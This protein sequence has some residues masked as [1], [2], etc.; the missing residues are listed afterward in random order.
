MRIFNF[1]AP[2]SLASEDANAYVYFSTGVRLVEGSYILNNNSWIR[3]DS[4]HNFIPWKKLH[5]ITEYRNFS[6]KLSGN[7]SCL[8]EVFGLNLEDGYV[9]QKLVSSINGEIDNLRIPLSSTIQADLLYCIVT[10]ESPE[11]CIFNISLEADC[12]N[13]N[14]VNIAY[15]ICSFNREPYV[16]QFIQFIGR[17]LENNEDI[18][19]ILVENG[20]HY[21]IDYPKNFSVI[22]NK[23][24]GG[25]GGFTRGIIEALSKNCFTHIILADDDISIDRESI[26]RTISLLK[27][28]KAEYSDC[29]ISGTM[30]SLDQKWLQY[31]RTSELGEYGFQPKGAYI[32]VRDNQRVI[33]DIINE[34]K[35][36]LAGW[37]YCCI[38]VRVFREF[39]LPL[40]IFV[41]G[42]DVEFSYRCNRRIITM[43]GVCVWHEPFSKKYNEIMED[44]YLVRNMLILSF[45]YCDKLS[46]LRQIFFLKKTIR[47][48]LLCDYIAAYFNL[49]AARALFNKEYRSRS[50]E[51]HCDLMKQLRD[52]LKTIQSWKGDRVIFEP[53]QTS[54]ILSLVKLFFQYGL[55]VRFGEGVS[56]GGFGRRVSSFLGRRQII[57]YQ[58]NCNY[59][60]Y[61]FNWRTAIKLFVNLAFLS[62][63][64]FCRHRNL[65]QELI[66]FRKES[67]TS[68]SW[69][70]IFNK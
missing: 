54:K 64:L 67:I 20:N 50:D 6:L 30:L 45:Q 7:G 17:D 65:E 10:S 56:N 44:Y 53:K 70:D 42:D 48:I 33:R 23:N 14:D 36:G 21:E 15:V 46:K 8:I 40:P 29:F 27:G 25:A 22:K 35:I 41:R 38:P 69:E 12:P 59:R 37:W 51:L 58:G 61:K 39:G 28:L 24:V 31:E 3:F 16:K 55:G 68:S 9:S 26:D 5:E 4:F 13:V 57:V 63:L 32:D 43:N 18:K 52:R 1:K 66:L 11:S 49:R 60:L 62:I 2:N 47:N 34:P 19:F